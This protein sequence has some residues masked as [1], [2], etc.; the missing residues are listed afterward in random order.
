[1]PK[2]RSSE[3]AAIVP[4]AGDLSGDRRLFGSPSLFTYILQVA[5][6]FR[7]GRQSF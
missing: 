2:F 3:R 5:S 7:S 6:R 4:S 1:V